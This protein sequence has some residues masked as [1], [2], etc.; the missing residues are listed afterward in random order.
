MTGAPA[1]F[2]DR[3]GVL[4]ETVWDPRA[5]ACESP[6]AP[7]DVALVAG[8]PDALR[9]LRGAG[10]ALVVASNQPSAAKGTAALG[11]LRA[12]HERVAQELAARN[13]APDA[14]RYCLHHPAGEHP[15]LAGPCPCRKPAPGLLLAAAFELG[16]DLGRSWMVGDSDTDVEA[17]RAAGC[18]TVLVHHPG[19]AHRRHGDA[20][21]DAEAEDL[22]GAADAIL[23]AGSAR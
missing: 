12:V 11:D 4:N 16:L 15:L 10:F 2:V 7:G 23:A 5:G 22:A 8:V 17:G 14:F 21:A 18:R 6:Y 13:A 3:D 1:I 9:A 19:S 20:D